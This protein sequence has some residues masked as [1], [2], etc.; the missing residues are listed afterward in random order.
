MEDA[1]FRAR[2][3]IA[4][5]PDG[6]VAIRPPTSPGTGWSE[7]VAPRLGQQTR[8]ILRDLGVDAAEVDSLLASKVVTAAEGPQ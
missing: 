4:K 1:H 3:A 7:R 8:A 6:L 5:G 2:G